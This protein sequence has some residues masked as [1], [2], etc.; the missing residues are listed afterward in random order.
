VNPDPD[1]PSLTAFELDDRAYREAAHVTGQESW[2]AQRPFPVTV[3]PAQLVAR[4]KP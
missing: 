2:A 1:K 3:V 4:L